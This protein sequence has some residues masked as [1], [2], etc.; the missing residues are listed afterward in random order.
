MLR[1]SVFRAQ[2]NIKIIPPLSFPK[3]CTVVL[4][5]VAGILWPISNTFTGSSKEWSRKLRRRGARWACRQKRTKKGRSLPM[6]SSGNDT[7]I[8]RENIPFG[9]AV[10]D[11]IGCSYR[12]GKRSRFMCCFKVICLLGVFYWGDYLELGCLYSRFHV[13]FR[14]F[15]AF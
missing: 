2:G 6:S 4:N 15:L 10:V 14:L 11:L 5:T 12:R 9:S 3:D 13:K 1:K 8:R 7:W